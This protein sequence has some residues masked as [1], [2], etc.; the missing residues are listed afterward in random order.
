MPP[1]HYSRRSWLRLS[2]STLAVVTLAACDQTGTGAGVATSSIPPTTSSLAEGAGATAAASRAALASEPAA[3][4]ASSS[5]MVATSTLRAVAPA[6]TTAV[7]V[8]APAFVTIATTVTVSNAAA[9]PAVPALPAVAL[10]GVLAA[11]AAAVAVPAAPV[12]AATAAV[13]PTAQ[14]AAAVRPAAPA[15]TGVNLALPASASLG[16]L[17]HITQTVNNCGPASVAEVLNY[18]GISRTQGQVQA[19]LRAD[20]SP[21]GMLPYGVPAYARSLG[22]GAVLGTGGDRTLIKALVSKGFP[23]IANQWVSLTDHVGHYRPIQSYDNRQG[24][25]TASDPFL[26][27]GHQID[28]TTFDRIWATNSGRFIL[29][30]PLSRQAVVQTV[31]AS[32]GWD[33]VPA[34]QADL[35]KLQRRLTLHQPSGDGASHFWQGHGALAIAWDYLEM[36][37]LT[38]ARTALADATT[39]GANPVVINWIAEAIANGLG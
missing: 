11:P 4:S 34:Y 38:A 36:G 13:A 21:N 1:Q 24:V 33:K 2:A 9:L 14:P 35:A 3:I 8:T 15:S 26:G 6:V 29:L 28:Y 32:A 19:V 39:Q 7:S 25:F 31:L 12:A 17:I 22:F 5:A 30:Y 20:G 23:P 27:Q 37:Q 10:P 18:W 16:P